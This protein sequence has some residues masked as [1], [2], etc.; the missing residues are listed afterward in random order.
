MF[1]QK[2]QNHMAAAVFVHQQGALWKSLH[3]IILLI[4]Q[5]QMYPRVDVAV[6]CFFKIKYFKFLYELADLSCFS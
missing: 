4:Q 2:Q 5:E 1:Y 3:W 6:I